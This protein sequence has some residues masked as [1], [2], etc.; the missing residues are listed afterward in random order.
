MKKHLKIIMAISLLSASA[1]ALSGC[2]GAPAV[3]ASASAATVP[4]VKVI[5]LSGAGAPGASGKIAPSQTTRIYAKNPGRVAAVNVTEGSKVK[6]GDVLVQLE[7]DDLTQQVN[8]AQAA[9]DQAQAALNDAQNG[10]RPQDLQAAEAGVAQAKAS[11]DNANAAVEGAKAA[12]DLATKTYNQVKNHYDEGAVSKSDLDNATMN[13]DKAKSGYEQAVAGQA[14]AKAALSA[15]QS[16]LDLARAGATA[17]AINGL[18]ARANQAQAALELAKNALEAASIKAPAD[19]TIVKKLIE[20]GEMAFTMMPSGTELLV[21]V[22][23][24]TVD[25]DVSVPE[26]MVAQVKEGASVK[27]TLPSIPDKTFDGTVTFV[28]P[29]SDQNNNTFPVKV[30]VK[31]SDGALRAGAV[32][33]V[34]FGGA[35][36]SRIELP[37]SAL[38]KDGNG[39]AV[40]KVDGDTVHKVAV[41]TEEKNQDW[42][43][44]K[45]DSALKANDKI[46]LKP[47]EK[48]AD[49]AKVRAE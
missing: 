35:Q 8:S 20:P 17:E 18:K 47:D 44:L 7:T 42:V 1:T 19:G 29:V 6:K 45:G 49:G 12:F 24:D 22:N 40:F 2:G 43:Y 36:Q 9:L 5:T 26:D 33:V 30:A 27:V 14:T 32:A 15:A 23:M 13:Y 4:S 10:A 31:N 37:K 16:K 41:Q 28:S 46:V 21:M 48:L 34:S 39:S 25:V 38:V 3:Q 11:V